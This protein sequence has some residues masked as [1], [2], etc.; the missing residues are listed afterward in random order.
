VAKP[1][2]DDW[3]DILDFDQMVIDMKNNVEFQ[4]ELAEEIEAER[5]RKRPK[6]RE[7][8]RR[9]RQRYP[10]AEK[11]RYEA[12]KKRDVL[13]ELQGGLCKLCGQPLTGPTEI[14]HNIPIIHGGTSDLSNLSLLHRRCNKLKFTRVFKGTVLNG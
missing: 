13:Y 3:D 14:D 5:A 1:I 7:Q 11:L 10:E 4:R 12:R 8:S 6:Q 2:D 9:Y